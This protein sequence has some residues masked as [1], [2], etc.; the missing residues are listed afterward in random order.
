[1]VRSIAYA[2]L[3]RFFYWDYKKLVDKLFDARY[4]NYVTNLKII[5]S[6]IRLEDHS[7]KRPKNCRLLKVIADLNLKWLLLSA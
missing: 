7:P 2:I 4:V 6:L 3:V 1:M 5:L